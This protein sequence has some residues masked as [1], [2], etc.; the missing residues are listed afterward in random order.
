ML[1]CPEGTEQT[2]YACVCVRVNGK[3]M[4]SC[5]EGTEQF[6]EKKHVR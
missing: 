5:P 6:R 3:G 2:V 4:L 1:S